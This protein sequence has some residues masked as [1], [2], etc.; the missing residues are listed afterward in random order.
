MASERSSF[1]RSG[2]APASDAAEAHRL[3]TEADALWAY[4]GDC[5]RWGLG[6]DAAAARRKS[7]SMRVGAIMARA[8]SG[9]VI[10]GRD[11]RP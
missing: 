5:D 8:M 4:A 7:V 1:D 2:A 10:A 9:A 6:F 11:D 3:D